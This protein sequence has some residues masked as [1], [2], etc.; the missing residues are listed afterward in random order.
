MYTPLNLGQLLSFVI[1]YFLI[2]YSVWDKKMLSF[3][4]MAQGYIF[5]K[6]DDIKFLSKTDDGDEYFIFHSLW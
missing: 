5:A 6:T 2:R 1:M 3:Y 4:I